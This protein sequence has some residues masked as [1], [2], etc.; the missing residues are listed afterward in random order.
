MIAEAKFPIQRGPKP[1]RREARNPRLARVMLRKAAV[2]RRRYF[3]ETRKPNPRAET[4]P[5]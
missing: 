1:C 4:I 2:S 5:A 3:V